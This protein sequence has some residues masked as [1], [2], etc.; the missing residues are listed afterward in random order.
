MEQAERALDQGKLGEADRALKQALAEYPT[1]ARAHYRQGKLS[2]K[3]GNTREAIAL[4][5]KT[6]EEDEAYLAAYGA[7]AE[8]HRQAAQAPELREISEA[9]EE[10]SASGGGC[11]LL[12]GP[13]S[14]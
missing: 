12:F 7:L 1:Y 5:Q 2:E 9:V 10:S 4:Y 6:L 8:L 3:L 11:S 13:R 14:L